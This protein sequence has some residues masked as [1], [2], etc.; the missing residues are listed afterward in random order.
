MFAYNWKEIIIK[1]EMSSCR[2]VIYCTGGLNCKCAYIILVH[3]LSRDSLCR[4]SLVLYA[5]IELKKMPRS[6]VTSYGIIWLNNHRR[7]DL[8]LVYITSG[9]SLVFVEIHLLLSSLRN[10]CS[11][12][13]EWSTRQRG[14]LGSF[15]TLTALNTFHMASWMIRVVATDGSVNNFK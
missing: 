5:S 8:S 6:R 12:L 3:E 14:P 10:L 15:R 11:R 13:L 1:K 4:L 7:P 9:F 2:Y